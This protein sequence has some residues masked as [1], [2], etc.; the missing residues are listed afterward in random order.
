MSESAGIGRGMERVGRL[1]LAV[2]ASVTAVGYALVSPLFAVSVAAGAALEGVNFHYLLLSGTRLFEGQP[3]SWNS[4]FAL[5]FAFVGLGL[6]L[7]LWA[8]AHPVGLVVGASLIMPIAV[9]EAWR[10]RPPILRDAPALPADDPSWDR[11]NPWLARE[12]DDEE[13]DWP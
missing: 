5:R 9:I 4:G 12:R 3:V 1:N 7:A 11:W 8:G 13:G 6:G 10:T 2:S